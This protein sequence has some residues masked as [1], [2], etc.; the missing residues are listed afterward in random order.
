M[1]INTKKYIENEL[2]IRTK[3]SQII[4]FIINEPQMKLYNTIKQ[5]HEQNKP[6]RIIILKA[7]QMGFSTL[8]EALI[9]K[10]TATK[11]NVNS[12]I[13]AHKEEA[14][15]N[16]FNM[17]QLFYEKL[18]NCLRP[19][20][21]KSN[22]K[23]L[24]FDNKEGT[25]LKSKIKC[26]TAGGEGIGRSDTFQNLHISEYAFWKGD[27]KNTLAGLLQAVPDTP[28]SMVIIES[29]ANG[30]DDFKQRWDD[31]VDGK[32][33]YVPLFCAWHELKSYRR[34]ATGI[35]LTDEEIELKQLYNLDDEQIAWRRWKIAND[36]GGDIDLFKQE[37]PSCPEEAF[38]SSGSSVF[39]K[40]SIVKQIE[41]VRNLQPV[42]R[43]YF[44]YEKKVIDVDNY[45]IN[46]IKWV[47]D[48]KGYITIHH[49]PVVIYDQKTKRPLRKAPYVIGCDVA[50]NGEDYFTAKVVD[51]ITH[52]RHATLHK[53]DIHEDLYA[54]QLYCL[55]MYYHEALIGIEVNYSIVAD[56]ELNKL[57][58]PHIYQREVFDKQNQR[59]M[60]Q[61]GFITNSVTRP[62]MIAKLVKLFR[63]D[64]THECDVATLRE[65][66]TFVK[67]E[68]GR[69]EAEYG[70]HDDLVMADAIAETIIEQQ[71]CDWIEIEQEKYEL[72]FALQS[73]DDV[74]DEYE[75]TYQDYFSALEEEF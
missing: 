54:D 15:T 75:D 69:A 63:E 59:F 71:D 45:E 24:I 53:Q 10:R 47:D 57:N 37:F 49:E 68:K 23:E 74:D 5:L 7:R 13:V 21:R 32:S 31:A 66:L 16:L 62:L 30:Y 72:P 25:G 3:D 29:T 40:E 44:E 2:W 18:K 43:G 52:D 4:P 17:S 9:F 36:C 28:D 34:D 22:A 8:T 67:N 64:I 56:R 55:G 48:E 46:N 41:R 70:F 12:G 50:G 1:A 35:V 58:Y 27:K 6:I 14:T 19:Q 42:K 20:I 26:M 61:T 39:D 65:C 33:D 60:K 51:C 38:I 73:E 11:H